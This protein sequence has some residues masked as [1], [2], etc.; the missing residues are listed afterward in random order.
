MLYAR[1]G[2]SVPF[3]SGVVAASLSVVVAIALQRRGSATARD[4]SLAA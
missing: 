3:I 1:L 4:G 2:P